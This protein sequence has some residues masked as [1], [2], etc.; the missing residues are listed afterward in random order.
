M[1][2]KDILTLDNW[3]PIT[4]INNDAKLLALIFAQRL[5]LCLHSIIDDCQSAFMS[6]RHIGNNIT[7]FLDLV[8]YRDYINENSYIFF[9]DYYKAFDTV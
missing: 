3:R 6:G 5:K 4:L 8:D 1:P 2:K 9:V 7:L